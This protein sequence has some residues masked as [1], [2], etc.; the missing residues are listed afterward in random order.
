M[1]NKLGE[2]QSYFESPLISQSFLKNFLSGQPRS[3]YRAK[4]AQLYYEEK[5]HY[6]VGSLID[7][8]TTLQEEDIHQTYYIDDIINKP[9]EKIM[10]I[11][12]QLYDEGKEFNQD[13]IVEV[14]RLQEYQNRYTPD[15]LYKAISPYE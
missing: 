3:I 1:S 6:I 9:S 4:E 11:I 7:F 5:K 2:I 12:H 14:C 10:S 15:G 13:N 8:L